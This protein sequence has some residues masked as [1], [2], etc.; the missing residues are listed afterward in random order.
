MNESIFNLVTSEN[1]KISVNHIGLFFIFRAICL[2]EEVEGIGSYK[3]LDGALWLC[4]GLTTKSIGH[5]L[6]YLM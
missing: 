5:L 2:K 1:N 3:Y 6:P 4:I